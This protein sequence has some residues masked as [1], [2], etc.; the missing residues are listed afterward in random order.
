MSSTNS[1]SNWPLW[2]GTGI[3]RYGN[4]SATIDCRVYQQSGGKG[5]LV[6]KGED[7]SE[8][9]HRFILADDVQ[10]EIPG[11]SEP[12]QV[13]VSGNLWNSEGHSSLTLK[14]LQTPCWFSRSRV[15]RS[16]RFVVINFAHYWMGSP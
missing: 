10:L 7:L 3:L 1:C 5:E 4:S 6:I 16:G 2:S 15:L 8:S 9:M 13:S 11:I 12:L 14:P